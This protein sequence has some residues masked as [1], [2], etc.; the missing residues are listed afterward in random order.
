MPIGRPG[1]L[2]V[3]ASHGTVGAVKKCF[4]FIFIGGV[5]LAA[6]VVGWGWH[7]YTAPGPLAAEHEV[8]I[9]RGTG[10]KAVARQLKDDGVIANETVFLVGAVAR[11]KHTAVKA[12]EYQFAPWMSA[13]EVMD[14]L[15]RGD[16]VTRSV[17]IPE[18]LTVAQ[19]AALLMAEDKLSGEVPTGIEEGSL[20]PETY[21]FLRGDSRASIVVRMQKAAEEMLAALWEARQEGLPLNDPREAVILASIVEKETG[22]AAERAHVA[23]VYVNRLRMGMKLQADPTVAYGI[24][25]RDG[26]MER[27][28]TYK[29]LETDTPY[30]TYTRVGLPAGPIANPGKASLEAALNP[31]ATEDIFFVATGDGSGAHWFART[32]EEHNANVRKYR[33]AVGAAR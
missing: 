31:M 8:L 25:A 16:V 4:A 22:L 21:Q 26:T 30:N 12:G 1:V 10:F 3:Y 24:V 5:L 33:A 29:D 18:G 32:V 11:G 15:A 2:I 28:L 13:A 17:T 20:L 9:S 14:K 27:S 6:A 19:I 23:G 7:G